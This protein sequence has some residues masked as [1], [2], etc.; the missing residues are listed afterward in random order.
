MNALVINSGSSSIKVA[1]F[2]DSTVVKRVTKEEV[3]N[4]QEAFLQ[5]VQEVDLSKLDFVAHRVV[6]GGSEFVSPTRMS[7]QNIDKLASLSFLAPLHNPYNVA[8]IEYFLSYHPKIVQIAVFDT[9]FHATIP[10]EAYR[11]ALREEFL[12]KHH[13]R[14]YGFHGSSHAYLLQEA[15]KVL[16]KEVAKTSVISLHIGNGASACAIQNGRSIDTSMGMTP[17][18]GLVMGSRCGD[19][20]AGVVLYMQKELGLGVDEVDRVLNKE[21]GLKGMC[22]T[23]DLK[24][25]T[26]RSDAKTK[27]ALLLYTRRIRKY[28]GAYM[29]LLDDGCDGLVFSGG[30]GEHSSVVR[31]MVLDGLRHFGI[32]YDKEANSKN[33]ITISTPRSKVAVFVIPTDEE[34][35]IF[36]TA[37]KMVDIA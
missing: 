2:R 14:R 36:N 33:A 22:G 24:E 11:Y 35:Y 37:K 23:N 7:V 13:I 16:K 34:I 31:A 17:L 18:E 20:D 25:I 1:V 4:H 5:I 29:A 9:A 3:K 30:V 6:H 28:I 19:I 12:E 32:E 10:P 21:S 26:K 27:E 8:G 15:A